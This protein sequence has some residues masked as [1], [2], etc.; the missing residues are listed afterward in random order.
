GHWTLDN[1][2][3]NDTFMDELGKLLKQC[4]IPFDHEDQQI[5][6]F[7]HIINICTGHVIKKITDINLAEIACAWALA[8]CQDLND[9]QTYKEALAHDLIA[10]GHA[11]ITKYKLSQMEWKVL[12]DFEAILEVPHQVIQALSYKKLPTVCD[13]LKAFE[14][15]YI[16]QEKMGKSPCNACLSLYIQEGLSWANKY[17]T[18]MGGTKA[19]LIFLNPN[20]CL[21]WIHKHWD[22]VGVEKTL[23]VIHDTVS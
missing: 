20:E 2:E 12:Q 6:C 17:Y 9:R 11:I 19:Y 5:R 7:P 21:K 4:N 22:S 23:M 1:A 14:R 18:C 3:N 13:Y 16:N 10:L 15:F 8:V